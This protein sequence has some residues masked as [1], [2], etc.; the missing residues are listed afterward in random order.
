[1]KIND[2][3]SPGS[4]PAVDIDQ[5]LLREL[6]TE[7]MTML[8]EEERKREE[9]EPL[10]F[11]TDVITITMDS[12]LSDITSRPWQHGRRGR[13]RTRH[14]RPSSSL[15]SSLSSSS[16]LIRPRLIR[17]GPLFRR[18]LRPREIFYPYQ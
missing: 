7:I 15:S 1:M 6:E 9:E 16:D 10:D 8:T 17:P 2:D 12:D 13:G 3:F 11:N 4:G 5:D 18:V 14:I